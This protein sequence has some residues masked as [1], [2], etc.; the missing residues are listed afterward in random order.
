MI[1]ITKEMIMRGNAE[2]IGEALRKGTQYYIDK[3]NEV[4]SPIRSTEAPMIMAA[5]EVMRRELGKQVPGAETASKEVLAMIRT[6]SE[7]VVLPKDMSE[8]EAK[9]FTNGYLRGRKNG[10]VY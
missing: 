8:D 7:K 1:H 3:I 2:G 9:A 5:L 4:I 6:E 10:R